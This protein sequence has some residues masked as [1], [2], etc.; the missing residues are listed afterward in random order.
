M[1][2]MGTIAAI[3]L[4]FALL[5]TGCGYSFDALSGGPAAGTLPENN[6]SMAVKVGDYLYMVNG[7]GMQSE[8]N[9]F[10]TP[11]KGTLIRVKLGTDG[12]PDGDSAAIVAPKIFYSGATNKG[13]FIFNDRIYYLSPSIQKN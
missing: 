8:N 11:V 6:G 5:F 3:L 1:K 7:Q 13:I 4:A 12:Q 10:G 2:R 9:E